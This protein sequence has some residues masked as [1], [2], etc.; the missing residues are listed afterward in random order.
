ME[1]EGPNIAVEISAIEAIQLTDVFQKVNSLIPDNQEVLSIEPDSTVAEAVELMSRHGFSQLPVRVG[2]RVLGIV[3]YRSLTLKMLELGKESIDLGQMPVDE[4]MERG[5]YFRVS[6]DITATFPALSQNEVVLIGEPER[7]MGIV[8]PLDVLQHLHKLSRPFILLAEIEL[9]IRKLI[10]ASVTHDEM[11]E[12]IKSTLA[13]HYDPEPCP[14]T[15]EEMSF[16]DYVQMIGDGRTWAKFYKVFGAKGDWHRKSLRAKLEE[17]RNMR[18]IVF[19]LKRELEPAE[20][21]VLETH[22]DWL[23]MKATSA[24]EKVN[25]RVP[26]Q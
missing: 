3:S 20:V 24:E 15:V 6:D 8:T 1:Q 4:F 23:L 16:N 14:T 25:Q 12:C 17:V 10:L 18:N 21:H 13:Q 9:A 11:Q 7:L 19:H 2:R 22:R 5:T 26:A